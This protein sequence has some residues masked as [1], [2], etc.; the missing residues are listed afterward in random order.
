MINSAELL[1]LISEYFYERSMPSLETIIIYS[2]LIFKT[3]EIYV[4]KK[5]CTEFC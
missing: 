1:W 2:G 4:S 3:F 5:K